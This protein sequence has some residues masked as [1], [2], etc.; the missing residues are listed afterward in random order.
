MALQVSGQAAGAEKLVQDELAR[1]PPIVPTAYSRLRLLLCLMSV[2]I[3]EG[4]I[5]RGKQ[6]PACSCRKRRLQGAD[7]P[8]MGAPGA[9]RIAYETNDLPRAL[10]HFTR[11][12][13]C[14]MTGHTRGGHECLVGLALTY[15]AMGRTTEAQ[16]MVRALE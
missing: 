9:G 15:Q 6:P 1:T 11:G 3:A 5:G 10:E 16:S 13:T 7:Q 4:N 2:Q 12:L 14:A 8:V